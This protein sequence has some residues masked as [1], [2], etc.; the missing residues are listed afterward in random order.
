[1]Y[2]IVFYCK[3]FHTRKFDLVV[4]VDVL[5]MDTSWHIHFFHILGTGYHFTS[6]SSE[7]PGKGWRRGDRQVSDGVVQGL[8]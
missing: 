2:Y 4:V 1:M 7:A 3:Y 6:R 8:R 5:N